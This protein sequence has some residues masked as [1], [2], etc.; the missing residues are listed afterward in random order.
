MWKDEQKPI[1]LKESCWPISPKTM[2]IFEMFSVGNNFEERSMLVQS[3]TVD[4]SLIRLSFFLSSRVH[5]KQNNR[6]SCSQ[7]TSAAFVGLCSLLDDLFFFHCHLHSLDFLCACTCFWTRWCDDAWRRLPFSYGQKEK[8][9]KIKV[10]CSHSRKR[11][12]LCVGV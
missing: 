2:K 7:T 6:L 5:G 10:Y 1:N 4:L 3:A 12:I 11:S 9:K 8:K